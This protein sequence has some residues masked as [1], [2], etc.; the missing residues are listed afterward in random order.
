MDELNKIDYFIS[1]SLVNLLF[2]MVPECRCVFK[3]ENNFP[4]EVYLFMNEFASFLSGEIEKSPTSDI[5]NNSFAFINKIGESSNLEVINILKIGVLE[6]L[7]TSK[8]IDR[9]LVSD[10]LSEKLQKYFLDFSRSYY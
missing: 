3:F 5:V 6:I 7:Y 9:K 2:N 8:N 1:Q 10:A 4:G